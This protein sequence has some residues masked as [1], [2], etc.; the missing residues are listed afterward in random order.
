MLHVGQLKLTRI[1]LYIKE[2]KKKK[3]KR[4]FHVPISCPMSCHV[5]FIESVL[6]DRL[7]KKE[8][9]KKKP[10]ICAMWV[11]YSIPSI[12]IQFVH[13]CPKMSVHAANVLK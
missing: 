7:E 13:K 1:W 10:D 12:F 6:F 11:Y 8:T 2:E 9:L 4:H 5:P 3:K